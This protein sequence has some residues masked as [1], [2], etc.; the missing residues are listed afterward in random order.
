MKR[1]ANANW[2]PCHATGNHLMGTG[3]PRRAGA[4]KGGLREEAAAAG[5]GFAGGGGDLRW[6]AALLVGKGNRTHGGED[7][8]RETEAVRFGRRDEIGRAH[9]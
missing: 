5:E 7:E 3:G 6:T 4:T 2:N 9:V 1:K 8:A